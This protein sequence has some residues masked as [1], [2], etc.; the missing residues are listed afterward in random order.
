MDARVGF[1]INELAHLE[2]GQ[3]GGQ[4]LR[5]VLL[6]TLGEFVASVIAQTTRATH[7][8]ND[9]KGQCIQ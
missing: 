8:G 7:C 6:K 5:A 1:H 2:V 4:M 3:I 9:Q